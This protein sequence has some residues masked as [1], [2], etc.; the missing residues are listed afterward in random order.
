M[1][2]ESNYF[3]AIILKLS[4]I[5]VKV[6]KCISMKYH[7]LCSNGGILRLSIKA[8]KLFKCVPVH[9][10]P[11]SQKNCVE[12]TLSAADIKYIRHLKYKTLIAK[13][14]SGILLSQC[15]WITLEPTLIS[16]IYECVLSWFSLFVISIGT[17]HLHEMQLNSNELYSYLTGIFH[18]AK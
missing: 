13:I 6:F 10:T 18:P 16:N 15:I 7:K 11:T 2:H 5:V 4:N 17:H 9:I 12:Y 14:L 1:T 8:I 3:I